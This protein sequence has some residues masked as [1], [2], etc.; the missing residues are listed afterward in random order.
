[1]TDDDKRS[2]RPATVGEVK[3]SLSFALRYAGRR[4][5]HTADDVM[6]T[7]PPSAWPSTCSSRVTC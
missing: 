7:S 6:A 1:M 3:D 2:L 5:V 4:R